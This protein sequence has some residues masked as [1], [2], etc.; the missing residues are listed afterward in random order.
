MI[1]LNMQSFFVKTKL[2]I[3]TL[4]TPLVARPR[5]FSRLDE[6]RNQ[7]NR[8]FLICAP[9]G[10]GKTTLIREWIES[11]AMPVAWYSIDDIDNSPDQFLAYLKTSLTNAVPQLDQTLTEQPQGNLS[12]NAMIE[13]I[14]ALTRFPENV[15]IV[16]DDFHHIRS[17]KIIDM[18]K[19]FIEYLPSNVTLAITSRVRPDLQLNKLRAKMDITEIR[20][21]DLRFTQ[22]ETADFFKI[23]CGIDLEQQTIQVLDQKIEGWASGLQLTAIKINANPESVKRLDDLQEKNSLISA[24][25]F[26]EVFKHQSENIKSFLRCTSVLRKFNKE[27]TAEILGISSRKANKLIQKIRQNNLFIIPLD[28][29]QTWFR[30]HSL[31]REMLN[32]KLGKD[33][34]Q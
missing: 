24:Y 18:T 11:H 30:Y 7:K 8:L 19:R 6:G 13:L 4:K 23:N 10:Y 22:Q 26:D 17:S 3:P 27:I 21:E 5:L 25:L 29:K 1:R 32:T 12:F 15:L 33:D 9:A 20:K 28:Q 14:N 2:F 16:F 34:S 31:F